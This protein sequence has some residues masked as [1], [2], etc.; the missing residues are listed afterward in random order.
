MRQGL[1]KKSSFKRHDHK[2]IR[3]KPKL[4]NSFVKKTSQS[5]LSSLAKEKEKK[6]LLVRDIVNYSDFF[7][8]SIISQIKS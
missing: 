3:L 6:T 8:S 5:N 1:L 2:F 4:L 7:R